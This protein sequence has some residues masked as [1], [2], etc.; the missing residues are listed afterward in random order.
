MM[1]LLFG[2]DS[3]V[4][5]LLR[6]TAVSQTL[7]DLQAGLGWFGFALKLT[8]SLTLVNL[9]TLLY[10]CTGPGASWQLSLQDR[11]VPS[12]LWPSDRSLVWRPH[13]SRVSVAYARFGSRPLT[14]LVKSSH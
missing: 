2:S 6:E 7:R 13:A 9:D 14:G 4:L 3:V 5:P 12:E 10:L 11:E 1:W 8:L